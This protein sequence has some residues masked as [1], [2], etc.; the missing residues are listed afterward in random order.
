MVSVRDVMYSAPERQNVC[1]FQTRLVD[2]TIAP[3][4]APFQYETM[5]SGDFSATTRK[6]WF[7]ATVWTV[8]IS[9][10]HRPVAHYWVVATSCDAAHIVYQTLPIFFTSCPMR[11]CWFECDTMDRSDFSATVWNVVMGVCVFSRSGTAWPS[12]CCRSNRG[13]TASRHHDTR[14][15]THRFC[16]K[17]REPN[18]C[19]LSLSVC[20]LDM[21]RSRF[22]HSQFLCIS[23]ECHVPWGRSPRVSV[24]QCVYRAL[25]EC[26]GI[27]L[28]GGNCRH[29]LVSSLLLKGI[30][31]LSSGRFVL[32]FLGCKYI[33]WQDACNGIFVEYVGVTFS[34]VP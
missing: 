9:V 11:S 18:S 19:L 13:V 16:A 27:E 1:T 4:E 20:V 30:L 14:Q 7:R 22:R 34:K 2:A 33:I 3:T 25:M 6:S 24:V 17:H 10:C 21:N 31:H 12:W 5:H 26:C 29:T 32:P 15:T 28:Y 8:L 23:I